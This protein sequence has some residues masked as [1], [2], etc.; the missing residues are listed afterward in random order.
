MSK[1]IIG[2]DPG[3]TG[4]CAILDEKENFINIIDVPT[5]AGYNKG[6][7]IKNCVNSKALFDLLSPYPNA[8]VCI[9]QVSSM[10]RD[11]AASAFSFGDTFGSIKAV[12]GCLG[13]ELRQVLPRIWKADFNISSD[14]EEARELAIKLV[15][16]AHDFLKRKKDHNRAEALLIAKWLIMFALGD[17]K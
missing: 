9:E 12:C 11:G 17:K 5:M 10:P 3:L 8:Y 2:I 13:Y 6:A 1:L 7:F 16:D 14:K 4:A 15:P